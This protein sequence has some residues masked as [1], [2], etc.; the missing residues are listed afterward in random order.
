[1]LIKI[2]KRLKRIITYIR[3][4]VIAKILYD[5]KY[6]DNKYFESWASPGW[7]WAVQDAWGR[8]HYDQNRNVPWPV[9]PNS[10]VPHSKNVEFHPSSFNVFH[11][12][13]VYF[14]AID[15]KIIIGKK[16][17]DC[18]ECRYYYD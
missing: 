7:E 18:A 16:R 2:I 12:S 1:M 3:G 13:G 4:R 9:F 11:S 6:L 8:R 17:L 10:F 15:A 5:K 14:Q